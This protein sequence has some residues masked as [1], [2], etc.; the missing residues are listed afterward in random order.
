MNCKCFELRE[1][2]FKEISHLE[3]IKNSVSHGSKLH[4][5][6]DAKILA[7]TIVLDGLN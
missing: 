5:I 4:H 7:Y 6:I 1:W 2:L 3:E